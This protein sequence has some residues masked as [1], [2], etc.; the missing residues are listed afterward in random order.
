[1]VCLGGVHAEW[2]VRQS[3]REGAAASSGE[4]SSVCRGSQAPP[5]CSALPRACRALIPMHPDL[6]YAGMLPPLD[7]PHHLRS[8][9]WGP[10]REGVVRRSAKGEGSWVDVGLDKDAHIP[11]ASLACLA[12]LCSA[13]ACPPACPFAWQQ[14]QR[15][16]QRLQP[17]HVLCVPCVQAV[18]QG[19]RLTLS[20]GDQ[21]S[22]ATVQGQQV[23][24][25][26][27]A[28]PTGVQWK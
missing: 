2:A 9:E 17:R 12:L 20:M 3:L 11:Q 23:L 13:L 1:M 25:A 22:S 16:Q 4:Q 18:R 21:P 15:Q 28:L 8:T 27:L 10:F 14:E 7:A 5:A 24:Q 19:V 6:K 26:Q